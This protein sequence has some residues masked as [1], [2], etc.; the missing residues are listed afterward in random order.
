VLSP[1]GVHVPRPGEG[2]AEALLDLPAIPPAPPSISPHTEGIQE[3]WE[4]LPPRSHVPPMAV[5]D[6]RPPAPEPADLRPAAAVR[7]QPPA[8]PSTGSRQAPSTLPTVA[9]HRLPPASPSFLE[10]PYPPVDPDTPPVMGEGFP[11]EPAENSA[12]HRSPA[13]PIPAAVSVSHAEALSDPS[14]SFSGRGSPSVIF[15]PLVAR[16]HDPA[17]IPP[18]GG[19]YASP[20]GRVTVA[21]SPGAVDEGVRVRYEP[22]ETTLPALL[23][24]PWRQRWPVT[25]PR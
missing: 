11:V 13:R 23:S 15:L 2:I 5:A 4:L 9:G 18:C 24:S 7:A 17:V 25:G 16:N 21:F 22:L 14:S 8:D 12:A 1:P 6:P 19:D 10:P 3:G 20:D